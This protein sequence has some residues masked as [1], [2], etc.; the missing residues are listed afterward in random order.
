MRERV[1]VP[2]PHYCECGDPGC[3]VCHGHCRQRAVTTVYRS[4]MEDETGTDVCEGCAEDCLDSGVFYT[5]ESI[6]PAIVN[7][8][9][10]EE[11]D[12]YKA[13]EKAKAIVATREG[14]LPKANVKGISGWEKRAGRKVEKEHTDSS[15][16]ADAIASHHH[17]ERPDYYKKLKQSGLAPELKDGPSIEPMKEPPGSA[18]DL[19]LKPRPKASFYPSMGGPSST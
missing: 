19:K 5:K 16:T 2:P 12:A 17:D 18:A 9:L 3:P 15:S 6:V 4:D 1:K 10:T 14:L 11:S 7:L 13:V 8:L